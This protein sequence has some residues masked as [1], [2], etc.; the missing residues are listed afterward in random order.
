MWPW[1]HLAI[2]YLAFSVLVH[3]T[4]RRPPTGAECLLVALGT[5]FP[6]LV[7]KPLAWVFTVLSSG[8]SMA[9][10]LF[11]AVPLSVFVLVAARRYGWTAA[12]A[13]FVVGY[14]LHLPGD[15]LY[16]PLLLGRDVSVDALLWPFVRPPETVTRSV[17]LFGRIEGYVT[18]Y[19][20]AVARPE[21]TAYLLFEA[22]L[23]G[24]AVVRWVADGRPFP[25]L[26]PGRQ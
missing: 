23:L 20:A 24:G 12:A 21:A 17:E 4:L 3:L 19:R 2:G 15:I 11:V 22:T 9:H 13:A 7:D 14:L 16:G 1:E 10:S 6:D 8:T 5:Q 18:L 26:R 25:T